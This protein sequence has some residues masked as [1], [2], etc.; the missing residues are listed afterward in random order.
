MHLWQ[1]QRH[2]QTREAQHLSASELARQTAVL[3]HQRRQSLQPLQPLR[4][5]HR[6]RLRDTRRQW[7]RL[8]HSNWWQLWRQHGLPHAPTGR[9]HT[10]CSVSIWIY[11]LESFISSCFRLFFRLFESKWL[12]EYKIWSNNLYIFW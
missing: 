1:G 9:V 3:C 11:N 5:P 2:R 10:T 6:A 8:A 4:L 12:Y 7:P